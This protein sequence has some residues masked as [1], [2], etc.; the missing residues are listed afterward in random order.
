MPSSAKIADTYPPL[1]LERDDFHHP[2]L[3]FC[4]SMIFFGKPA[5]T[6]PDHALA[7]AQRGA[8]ASMSRR[9][10]KRQGLGCRFD[11]REGAGI[12]DGDVEPVA[13]LLP[14]PGNHRRGADILHR[15]AG[16][17]H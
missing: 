13:V 17:L 10:S 4:L 12:D 14:L 5:S 3:A 8:A 2:S 7:A 1:A 6:F 15:L 9:S 16:P 11:F